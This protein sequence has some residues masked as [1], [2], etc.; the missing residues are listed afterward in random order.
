MN[1]FRNLIAIILAGLMISIALQG[2][3]KT[4][5]T[6]SSESTES[7]SNESIQST[8]EQSSEAD[9]LAGSVISGQQ[10]SPS[11]SVSS[12]V[13][14]S[15][16]HVS[17]GPAVTPVVTKQVFASSRKTSSIGFGMY[18]VQPN[19][20]ITPEFYEM[21]QSDYVNT[22]IIDGNIETIR[23]TVSYA[24]NH[25][26]KFWTNIPGFYG[27][28]GLTDNW[29][30]RIDSIIDSIAKANAQNQWLGFYFDEPMLWGMTN[31]EL[32][33]TTKYMKEK[34]GKRIFVCFSIAGFYQE[35]W[36]PSD[37]VVEEVTKFGGTY[38]T[39]VAYDV[40]EPF[41]ADAFKTYTAKLKEKMGRDD[42][43]M[44]YVPCIMS[45][46]GTTDEAYAQKHLNGCFNL[47]LQEKHPGGIMGYI[48]R[49]FTSGDDAELG[50]KGFVDFKG[51]WVKLDSDIRRI[52][53]SICTREAFNK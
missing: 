42:F 22:F 20:G 9:S 12:R 43:N 51:Q 21:V 49:S 50:N 15:S 23:E 48:Y 26:S 2:C 8:S 38:L 47:L 14:A 3:A 33:D 10:S 1:H 44:W 6:I 16:G 32:H 46:R 5:G 31:Q 25:N 53:K 35:K 19:D 41:S 40:Y 37:K 45:Y 13:P 11:G 29:K 24:K 28:A 4:T 17:S 39:D 7:I 52:G 18:G 34:S 30:L 36:K 27:I